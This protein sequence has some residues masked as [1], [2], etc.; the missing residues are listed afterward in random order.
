MSA[1]RNRQA[2][3]CTVLRVLSTPAAS[4]S[5][6]RRPSSSSLTGAIE[7]SSCSGNS[8]PSTDAAC[9]TAG[10]TEPVEAGCEHAVQGG[11]DRVGVG[12]VAGFGRCAD[13]LLDEEWDAVAAVGHDI[14]ELVCEAG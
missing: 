8:R 12:G 10:R 5:P 6:S 4:R 14:D 7:A 11:W 13:E 2:T 3:P 1:W 9:A